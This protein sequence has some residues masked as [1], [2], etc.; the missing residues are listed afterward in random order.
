M[1][2][3]SSL[4][5]LQ[6]RGVRFDAIMPLFCN[7]ACQRFCSRQLA[8]C[9]SVILCTL[10]VCMHVGDGSV[11][12]CDSMQSQQIFSVKSCLHDVC[13]HVQVLHYLLRSRRVSGRLSCAFYDFVVCFLLGIMMGRDW[14]G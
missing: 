8:W 6:C 9:F 3:V 10:L 12:E 2:F 1:R 5:A 7:R 14:A 13:G 4:S 11:V